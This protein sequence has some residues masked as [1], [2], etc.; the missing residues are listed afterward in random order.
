MHST[1]FRTNLTCRLVFIGLT[2]LLLQCDQG[3]N[4]HKGEN[5]AVLQGSWKSDSIYTF[6]NGFG[7]TRHDVEDEPL[8]HY[9]SDGTLKMTKGKESRAFS[10][11][12]QDN[13]SLL[14]S[15]R[16]EQILEKFLIV[17]LDQD[18]LVLKKG[19]RPIFRGKNQERYE[20]WYFSKVKE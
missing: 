15:N 11:R 10:Y 1:L 20:I 17:K 14:H 19:M 6:Y 9:Q 5:I 8:I 2:I 16:N 4:R 7:F 13:D 18:K 3:D 12:V